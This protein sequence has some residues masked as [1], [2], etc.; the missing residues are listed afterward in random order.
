VITKRSP[1]SSTAPSEVSEWVLASRKHPDSRGFSSENVFRNSRI[2]VLR[3]L[4]STLE[5]DRKPRFRRGHTR[6]KDARIA[7]REGRK[8]PRIGLF[9][10]AFRAIS[11]WSRAVP[12]PSCS[13]YGARA[14]AESEQQIWMKL[15]SFIKRHFE[16]RRK[17][18][19]GIPI[20]A[21][22]PRLLG[23]VGA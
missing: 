8:A 3:A 4:S 5:T 15:A 6:S 18:R 19:E 22:V 13:P 20:G 2:R 9:P 16:T 14:A 10:S 12:R 1:R 23:S 11:S 21:Q 7:R 17:Q